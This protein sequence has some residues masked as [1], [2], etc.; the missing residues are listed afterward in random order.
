MG[1][2]GIAILINV[3]RTTMRLLLLKGPIEDVVNNDV[4]QC[5]PRAKSVRNFNTPTQPN[6]GIEPTVPLLVFVYPRE[7]LKPALLR[8]RG[9]MDLAK[10]TSALPE[11][12]MAM[13]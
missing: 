13:S 10:S 12:V 11:N 8:M 3:R 5:V 4:L 9:I 6:G 7:S 2:A 1:L